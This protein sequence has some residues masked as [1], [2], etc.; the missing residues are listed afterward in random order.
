MTTHDTPEAVLAEAQRSAYVAL[1]N[2]HML[3]VLE[4]VWSDD[5]PTCAR[6][7][8]VSAAAILAAPADWMLVPRVAIADWTGSTRKDAEIARLREAV[9]FAAREFRRLDRPNS[10]LQMEE[11]LAPS[12]P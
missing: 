8:E 7:A 5:C 2:D 11:A 9:E 4:S 3:D 10:V 1:H 6:F 12:E